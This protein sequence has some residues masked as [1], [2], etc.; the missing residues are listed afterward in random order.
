MPTEATALRK[1]RTPEVVVFD[2]SSLSATSQRPK[3]EFKNF[4]S[5]KI[6]KI[7]AKPS[8]QQP[9]SKADKKED[10]ESRQHDLELKELLEGRLMI[11]KLHESQLYGKDRHTHNTQ[12]LAKLGMKVKTKD[13]LPVNQYISA[14]R[15]RE[16]KAAGLLQDAKDRGILNTTLKREI[17]MKHL[18]K[19]GTG[20]KGGAKGRPA[21]RAG[22]RGPKIGS[23]KFKDGILHI[24]RSH[25]DRVNNSGKSQ[26]RVGKS[27]GKGKGKSKGGKRR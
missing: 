8:D 26:S 25:I 10:Q 23:G 5:S 15:N 11:E 9:Q 13:N 17:E 3:A 4:M 18:G 27:K 22:D 1:K 16:K 20:S 19:S 14:Q 6:S 24:S 12:K 2:G 7:D 21:H